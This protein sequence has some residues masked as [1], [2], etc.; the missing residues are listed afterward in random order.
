MGFGIVEPK[1]AAHVP[2]T[3]LLNYEKLNSDTVPQNLKH[4]SGKDS[5]IVLAPQPADDPN[6]PLNWSWTEKLVVRGILCLDLIVHAAALV[7]LHCAHIPYWSILTFYRDLCWQLAWSRSL[8][9]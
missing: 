5:Q 8:W 9:S 6:D 3:V 4:A 2:G 1:T 7:C